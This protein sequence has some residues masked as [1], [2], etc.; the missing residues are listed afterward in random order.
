MSSNTM[1]LLDEEPLDGEMEYHS[2]TSLILETQ[3][4]ISVLFLVSEIE[5][6]GNI[7][8]VEIKPFKIRN[9]RELSCLTA[10]QILMKNPDLKFGMDND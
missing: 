9:K 5:V 6:Q 8:G 2:K 10:T 3:D 1:K 7:E 4:G